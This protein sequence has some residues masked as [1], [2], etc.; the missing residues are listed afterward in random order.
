M[1]AI[2]AIAGC[3]NENYIYPCYTCI[4]QE[5]DRSVVSDFKKFANNI[6][7]KLDSGSQVHK[8]GSDYVIFKRDNTYILLEYVFISCRD[9][10][11]EIDMFD[12]IND[13]EAY[14]SS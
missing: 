5:N 2:D 7:N 14:R 9:I 11:Y 6:F 8:I 1:S 4:L 10:D 3:I 13:L 12:S